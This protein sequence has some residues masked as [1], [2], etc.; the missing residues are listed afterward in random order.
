MKIDPNESA[1]TLEE[2]A[3]YLDKTGETKR[4]KAF[5]QYLSALLSRSER[6]DHPSDPKDYAEQA[7]RFVDAGFAELNG[8]IH[9][10]TKTAVTDALGQ[11]NIIVS[12]RLTD[13][14]LSRDAKEL[15]AVVRTYCLEKIAKMEGS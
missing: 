8:D 3:H 1:E 5:H 9:R 7:M 15:G 13:S 14:Q 2:V 11:L 6:H 12:A 4:E 10:E